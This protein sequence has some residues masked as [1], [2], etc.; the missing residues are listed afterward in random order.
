MNYEEQTVNHLLVYLF[1]DILRIEEHALRIPPYLNLSMREFHVIQA[2]CHAGEK[3]SMSDIAQTL[4]VTVGTLTVS[5]NTLIKKGYIIKQ[6]STT[7]RRM[8]LV[9]PTDLG[10]DVTKHHDAFH[11]EMTQAVT[12][13]LPKEQL[14]TLITTLEAIESYFNSKEKS[15]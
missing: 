3:N 9:F 6:R 4:G 10:I 13:F 15:K 11:T 7:D 2:V 14:S 12:S 1:N 5:V 8:V